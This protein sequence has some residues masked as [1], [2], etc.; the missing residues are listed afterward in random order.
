MKGYWL[1]LG[2]E[3][4][5]KEAQAEYARLFKPIGARYGAKINSTEIVPQLIEQRADTG[6]MLLVEFPSLEAAKAC[7]DDPEYREAMT[8]ANK[9]SRRDLVILAGDL[10]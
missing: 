6:R 5:D 9:A 1:V 8:F 3:V 2:T 7:Y 4:T 10:G